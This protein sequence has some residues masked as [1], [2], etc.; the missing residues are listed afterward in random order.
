MARK[1]IN[2]KSTGVLKLADTEAHL[3]AG[4]VE[5]TTLLTAT[6]QCTAFKVVPRPNTSTA[7]A[8]FSDPEAEVAAASSWEVQMSLL[9]DW[10]KT[11]SLSKFL[12]D[13]DGVLMW[14]QHDP[15]GATEDGFKGQVYIVSGGYGGKADDNWVD[16]LV[17]QAPVKPTRIAAA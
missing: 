13:N 2:P 3:T 17:F 1:I 6:E 9:Q 16:D 8:T 7:P 4:G 12:Y 15:A 10:G 14:F 11:P 5:G